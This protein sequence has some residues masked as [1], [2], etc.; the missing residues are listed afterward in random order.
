MHDQHVKQSVNTTIPPRG[1]P[2]CGLSQ[3]AVHAHNRGT[4][5]LMV[6]SLLSCNWFPDAIL[7]SQNRCSRTKRGSSPVRST[8]RRQIVNHGTM[9]RWRGQF[10]NL[11]QDPWGHSRQPSS[12][13]FPRQPLKGVCRKSGMENLSWKPQ[14]TSSLYTKKSNWFRTSLTWKVEIRK[15]HLEHP[16]PRLSPELWDTTEPQLQQFLSYC[17]NNMKNFILEQTGFGVSMKREFLKFRKKKKV[18]ERRKL[19]ALLFIFS[20]KRPNNEFLD[21]APPGT[22]ADF[23]DFTNPTADKPVPLLLDGPATHTK[24]LYLVLLAREHHVVIICFPPHCTHRMLPLDPVLHF[25]S[26]YY[27]QEVDKWLLQHPG[28]SVSEKQVAELYGKAFMRATLLQTGA[29]VEIQ[30]FNKSCCQGGPKQDGKLNEQLEPAP[31]TP[32]SSPQEKR[33]SSFSIASP[34][35]VVKIPHSKRNS[36]KSRSG[37]TSLLTSTPY[38]DELFAAESL[39]Q[40]KTSNVSKKTQKV[41]CIL[42]GESSKSKT[43]DS[44]SSSDEDMMLHVCTAINFIQDLLTKKAVNAGVRARRHGNG[45]V[46]P[47][48]AR[49]PVTHP[50]PHGEGASNYYTCQ[51]PSSNARPA[52]AAGEAGA[53]R[54]QEKKLREG[55][56][57]VEVLCSTKLGRKCVLPKKLESKLA[58]YCMVTEEMFYGL[59]TNNIRRL[60]FQLEA[61]KRETPFLRRQ[62]SSRTFYVVIHHSHCAN[63]KLFLQLEQRVSVKRNPYKSL[64]LVNFSPSKIFNV[65]ETGLTAVQHNCSKVVCLKGKKQ[66]TSL[67]SPERGALIT[68]VT[69]M[70]ASGRYITPM[71]VFPRKNMKAELIQVT[72]PDTIAVCHPS[73]WIQQELF[74]QWMIHFVD[75]VKPKPDDPVV[76]VLDGH[77][78]HS[79]N[80]DVIEIGRKRG[81]QLVCLPPHSTQKLQTL[82]VSFLSSLKTYYAKEI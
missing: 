14:R 81:V 21:H 34:D 70:S 31:V 69:C 47:G 77:Y 28:R 10:W 20:R 7:N 36:T 2:R 27:T 13:M 82:D 54:R 75:H 57:P 35:V 11:C 59:R 17:D 26:Q 79:R 19:H 49:L 40:K 29:Q 18:Q 22:T 16:K 71:L 48:P 25:L 64:Q 60:A 5:L 39:N 50:R 56:F 73:G 41:S 46:P 76:L 68:L 52:T 30:E 12:S 37:K 4:C 32:H 3:T 74:T 55:K 42:F 6:I 72:P 15:F 45:D 80:I 62:M 38:K 1:V 58:E 24:S 63:L 33:N 66:V 8:N 67:S 9:T 51:L 53:D 43:H 78:S 23:V 65:D 61:R 44:N